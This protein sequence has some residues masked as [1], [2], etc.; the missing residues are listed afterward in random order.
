METLCTMLKDNFTQNKIVPV[1][2]LLLSS[3]EDEMLNV[4]VIRKMFEQ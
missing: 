1:I 2:H 3:T 4:D